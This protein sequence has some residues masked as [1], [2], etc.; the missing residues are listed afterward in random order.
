MAQSVM[1][2][3][4]WALFFSFEKRSGLSAIHNARKRELGPEV[5]TSVATYEP[6]AKGSLKF[7]AIYST[8]P[9]L[10]KICRQLAEI[11]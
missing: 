10:G 7:S 11:F 6:D 2:N 5:V 3:S 8:R 9:V 1:K 4:A